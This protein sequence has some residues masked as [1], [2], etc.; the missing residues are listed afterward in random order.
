MPCM[1][2]CSQHCLSQFNHHG[3]TWHRRTMLVEDELCLLEIMD[4]SVNDNVSALVDQRIRDGDAFLLVYGLGSRSSFDKI[5]KM[6]EAVLQATG[7]EATPML[8]V[9]VEDSESPKDL[10]FSDGSTLAQSF[11]CPFLEVSAKT[12]TKLDEVL[13]VLVQ[14]IVSNDRRRLK[15]F[16]H[17]VHDASAFAPNFVMQCE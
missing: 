4:S 17:A 9:G 8:L 5:P 11:A 3:E 14:E 13:R 15:K 10:S 12:G 6:R 2:N 1:R 7:D 16:P